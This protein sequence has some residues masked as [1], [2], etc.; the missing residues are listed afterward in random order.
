MAYQLIPAN[1]VGKLSGT[2]VT[3]YNNALKR[4][5]QLA[6]IV[7]V[8]KSMADAAKKR[9]G[10]S[11]VSMYQVDSSNHVFLKISTTSASGSDR[12][13]DRAF[14]NDSSLSKT[15]YIEN[16]TTLSGWVQNAFTYN[17]GTYAGWVSYTQTRAAVAQTFAPKNSYVYWVD[18]TLANPRAAVDYKDWVA[19]AKKLNPKTT[20]T[21][22]SFPY[23]NNGY[24]N[25]AGNPPTSDNGGSSF[26]D[27]VEWFYVL[28]DYYNFVN[29]TYVAAQKTLTAAIVTLKDDAAKVKQT[30]NIGSSSGGGG[31]TVPDSNNAGR[32]G[33]GDDTKPVVY[34]L[35]YAKESYFRDN[36]KAIFVPGGNSP[37]KVTEAKQ[38][39]S[40]V[41]G[42]KGMIQ[43]YIVPG[44]LS[45]DSNFFQ[46]GKNDG[47]S[48]SN[49]N[50]NLRRYGFQF[51]YNPSTVTMNYAGAPQV[52][53]GLITS[54]AD[55]VPLI[56]SSVTSSNLTF[57]VILNRMNDFKYLD[58]LLAKG[59]VVRTDNNLPQPDF[60]DIYPH[61][62]NHGKTENTQDGVRSITQELERLKELGT[63]YDVEYLLR[64]LIG[65]ELRSYLKGGDFT[66]DVGYLGAYPVELHLGNNLRYLGV[67]DNFSLTHTIFSKDMI[68]L[69]TN[70]TITFSRLPDFNKALSDIVTVKNTSTDPTKPTK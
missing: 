18:T 59:S 1:K 28:H 24:S 6:E 43:S 12:N 32:T 51:M 64:T 31:S 20:L 62:S 2:D 47:K 15:H 10:K 66:A 45:K 8:A 40:A 11:A 27:D 60:H 48:A 46:P 68:P 13:R 70:L 38:L 3:T 63:M 57:S 22:F 16:L 33:I 65:Y 52:D 42:S 9:L 30:L 69:F 54:G 19:Q 34:N 41:D 14:P 44:K 67:I 61:G 37:Q 25:K 29:A 39:W 56:G 36:D 7:V 23:N 26:L 21:E 4:A 50:I 5:R 58:A 35:P 53:P 55:A 17:T 49:R